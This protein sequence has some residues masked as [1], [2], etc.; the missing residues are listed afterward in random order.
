MGQARIHRIGAY[1][2]PS[3]IENIRVNRSPGAYRRGEVRAGQYA[4]NHTGRA[5]AACYNRF[6]P[7]MPT[8]LIRIAGGTTGETPNM[9][10]RPNVLAVP[11]V[12]I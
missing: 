8:L 1:E 11:F 12:G 6:V 10:T 7:E 9:V 2:I 3:P 4:I 5:A